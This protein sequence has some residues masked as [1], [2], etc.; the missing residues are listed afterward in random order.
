[1]LCAWLCAITRLI[2]L[3]PVRCQLC[4]GTCE[5]RVR[6]VCGIWMMGECVV[7][8]YIWTPS[9]SWAFAFV[10]EGVRRQNLVR[11]SRQDFPRFSSQTVFGVA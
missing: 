8:N 6:E 10:G 2:R 7:A 1:M 5:G 9:G 3:F 4:S 11:V